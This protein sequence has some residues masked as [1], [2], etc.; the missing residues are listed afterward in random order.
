MSDSLPFELERAIAHELRSQID[1]LPRAGA[2]IDPVAV[3]RVLD[4]ERPRRLL[5]AVRFVAHRM[6]ER[7]ELVATR[8]GKP[9]TDWPWRGVIRLRKAQGGADPSTPPAAPAEPIEP[10]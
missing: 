9:I 5:D 3:A 1:A 10:D 2:T 4:P 6:A 8:H 7:G